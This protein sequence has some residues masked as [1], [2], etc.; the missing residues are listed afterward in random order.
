MVLS[1]DIQDVTQ[2]QL[3]TAMIGKQIDNFYP[4]EY[5]VNPNIS[6]LRV[7]GLTRSPW[8]TNVSFDLY[9]GEVLGIA[10]LAGSGK[11][12]ILRCLFGDM[13]PSAGYISMK[14]ERLHLRKPS[15]AIRKGIVF[16]TADRKQEGLIMDRIDLQQSFDRVLASICQYW[17]FHSKN[18]GAQSGG[19]VY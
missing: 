17:W 1:R 15:D 16:L 2:E 18:K 4:K 8:F 3:V 10:G 7:Q 12:E 13:Q 19:R 9:K 6:V 14:G 5:N 11:S